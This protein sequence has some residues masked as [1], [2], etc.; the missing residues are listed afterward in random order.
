MH[1]KSM[2]FI[3]LSFINKIV[4]VY[5]C[6]YSQSYFFFKFNYV[7]LSFLYFYLAFILLFLMLQIISVICQ[8]HI[9]HFNFIVFLFFL[10]LHDISNICILFQLYLN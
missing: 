8:G 2:S 7:L 5:I 6:I 1:L 3:N 4:F 10:S 9:C